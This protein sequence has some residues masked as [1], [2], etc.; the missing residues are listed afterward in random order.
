MKLYHLDW[1]R[2]NAADSNNHFTMTSGISEN[3][4]LCL[5]AFEDGFYKHVADV[6]SDDLEYLYKATQNGVLSDSWSQE[7]PE[8]I[9]PVA[10]SVSHHGEEYGLR[11]TSIGDIVE[12]DGNMYVVAN[13]GF[14]KMD[15]AV[16]WHHRS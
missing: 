15:K 16:D 7:P 3:D 5:R 12:K 10:K 8:W 1:E 14:K 6:D 9:K 4:E 11:S 13:I 2:S